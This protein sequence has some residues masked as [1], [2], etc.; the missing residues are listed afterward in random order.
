VPRTPRP[1]FRSRCTGRRT[2]CKAP[3][4]RRRSRVSTLMLKYA[5]AASRSSNR[6][7]GPTK[8]DDTDGRRDADK[9]RG[10]D[11]A[12]TGSLLRAR[13][14]SGRS[15]PAVSGPPSVP[16]SSLIGSPNELI[17]QTFPL[18]GNSRLRVSAC[19]PI[20]AEA[21]LIPLP[22]PPDTAALAV[23]GRSRS[24]A[25]AERSPPSPARTRRRP[26]TRGRAHDSVRPCQRWAAAAQSCDVHH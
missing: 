25:T 8:A 23:S 10:A 4:C 16:T 15:W 1:V 24:V 19:H 11:G 5:A 26:L 3:L 17:P 22:G 2:T 13:V 7:P 18:P 14:L 6:G 12:A 20:F 21:D 9:T